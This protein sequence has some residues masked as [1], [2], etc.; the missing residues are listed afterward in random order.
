[1]TQYRADDFYNVLDIDTDD[2]DPIVGEKV[3]EQ[4]IGLLNMFGAALQE[5]SGTEGSMYGN[6]TL[7]QWTAIVQV[8]RMVYIDFIEDAGGNIEMQGITKKA[9]SLLT[10]PDTFELIKELAEQCVA[11]SG[12]SPWD[13]LKLIGGGYRPA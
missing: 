13:E 5:M 1:M 3:L 4:A 9:R 8:A 2:L 7:I 6:Y 10:E 11:G 12:D